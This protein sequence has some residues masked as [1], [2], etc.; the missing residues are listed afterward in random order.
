M[1]IAIFGYGKMGQLIE[2]MALQH[3]YQVVYIQDFKFSRGSINQASVAIVFSTPDA[4]IENIEYAFKHNLNVVCGSTGWLKD[5]KKVTQM[6]KQ[7]KCGFLYASNF[8]IGVNVLFE[9]NRKLAH[10]MKS[11]NDY[12]VSITETHHTEKLDKPS[13]TAITL[14]EDLVHIHQLQNWTI[15]KA[16]KDELQINSHRKAKVMGDHQI[17]Y[18]SEIDELSIVHKAHNRNGFAHGALI[19]AKWIEHK[20]GIF[21]MSDVLSD[22]LSN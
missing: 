22:T 13:G 15:Q 12:E 14:A 10:T 1:K 8:S 19:A 5:Y 9:M 20:I 21:N 2:K 6:T 3:S 17:T 4:V 11:L 18:N 7:S 16:S